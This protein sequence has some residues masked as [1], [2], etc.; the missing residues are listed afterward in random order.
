M[1]HQRGMTSCP[2]EK[3]GNLSRI[4]CKK[5]TSGIAQCVE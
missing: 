4:E 1:D 3:P 5:E 2:S